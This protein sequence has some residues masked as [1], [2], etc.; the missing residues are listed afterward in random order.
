MWGKEPK[1]VA[2]V[3]IFSRDD[4]GEAGG[5]IVPGQPVKMGEYFES[6]WENVYLKSQ[7]GE[8]VREVAG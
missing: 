3:A 2:E 7:L 5:R 4:E 6:E 8:A 1:V